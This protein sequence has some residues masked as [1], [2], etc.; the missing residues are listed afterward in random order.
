MAATRERPA[1]RVD[2]RN[3]RHSGTWQ[4][5]DAS[6]MT[7]MMLG[8]QYAAQSQYQSCCDCE[9]HRFYSRYD[10]A[11]GDRLPVRHSEFYPRDI[12]DRNRNRLAKTGIFGDHD[13]ERYPD[14]YPTAAPSFRGSVAP[15]SIPFRLSIQIP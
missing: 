15:C 10:R 3:V 13:P 4:M 14:Q 1:D 8:G 5:R 12:Q 2:C 6:A 7:M 11:T 9:L